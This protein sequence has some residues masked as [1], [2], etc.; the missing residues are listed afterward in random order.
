MGCGGSQRR[1]NRYHQ[2]IERINYRNAEGRA[3]AQRKAGVPA[4]R[5]QPFQAF[6]RLQISVRSQG[7]CKIRINSCRFRPG[8]DIQ[9]RAYAQIGAGIPSVWLGTKHGIS[10][11]GT[12]GSDNRTWIHTAPP[13]KLPPQTTR[14]NTV[15]I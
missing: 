7:R 15:L 2:Y 11:K 8:K 4:H 6:R 3:Q 12:C 10:D 14:T 13:E 1:G 9:G 5:R